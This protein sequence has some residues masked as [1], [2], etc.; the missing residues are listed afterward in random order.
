MK[1][2]MM[3]TV[4]PNEN[5]MTILPLPEGATEIVEGAFSGRADLKS[6]Q[7]PDGVVRIGDYAFSGCSALE[8]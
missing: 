5:P 8:R 2:C 3:D 4:K 1:T 7:I 6:V